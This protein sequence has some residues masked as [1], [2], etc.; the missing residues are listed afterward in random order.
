M[1][2]RHPHPSQLESLRACTD[3]QVRAMRPRERATT[4]YTTMRLARLF[5]LSQLAFGL[6]D[7]QLEALFGG[8]KVRCSRDYEGKKPGPDA[9]AD[10]GKV[11]GAEVVEE[12]IVGDEVGCVLLCCQLTEQL[13][14][15]ANSNPDEDQAINIV[16][17]YAAK[18]LRP[19][20]FPK[21]LD[22]N[23]FWLYAE[24]SATIAT[25]I[26]RRT[27]GFPLC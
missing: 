21:A 24:A 11:V 10:A 27:T 4:Y 19:A 5:S 20:C 26:P 16:D 17:I 1:R 25:G 6:C 2:S 7:R 3:L 13:D 12:N 15:D 8:L 14:E 22:A 18:R 23:C 9:D